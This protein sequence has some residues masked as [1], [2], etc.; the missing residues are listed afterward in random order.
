MSFGPRF[1]KAESTK[2]PSQIGI[3]ASSACAQRVGALTSTGIEYSREMRDAP[4][5]V[6]EA[7]SGSGKTGGL[8]SFSTSLKRPSVVGAWMGAIPQC[9]SA[10]ASSERLA[11][12]SRSSGRLP[13]GLAAARTSAYVHAAMSRGDGTKSDLPAAL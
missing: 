3:P 11:P 4:A 10:V 7:M 2:K 12:V 8:P 9:A 5:T 13:V 6:S 1:S